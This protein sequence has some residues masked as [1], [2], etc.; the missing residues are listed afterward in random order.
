MIIKYFTFGANHTSN[1]DGI[2]FDDTWVIKIIANEP[3]Q[4]MF[5]YFGDKWSSEYDKLPDTKIFSGGI[6]DI[7]KRRRVGL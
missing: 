7:I 3:R 2:S 1:L 5:K 4:V 6:Y